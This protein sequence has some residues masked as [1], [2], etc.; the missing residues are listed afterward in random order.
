MALPSLA[1]RKRASATECAARMRSHVCS[2][3]E[4]IL[5]RGLSLAWVLWFTC[6]FSVKRSGEGPCRAAGGFV[7]DLE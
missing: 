6:L 1:R 7:W 4:R 3:I 5:Q 2:E